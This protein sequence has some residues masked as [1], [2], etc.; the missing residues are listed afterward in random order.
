MIW[1]VAI[2][3]DSVEVHLGSSASLHLVNFPVTDFHDTVNGLA[4]G[5]N[6][7]G[8]G[9]P[10]TLSL[11]IHWTTLLRVNDSNEGFRGSYFGGITTTLAWSI[12]QTGFNLVSDPGS[13]SR[14]V[15]SPV[16]DFGPFPNEFVTVGREQNGV[17]F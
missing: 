7:P 17:F 8:N 10:A 11:D 5:S 16:I 2:P 14:A 13:T 1:T 3:S 9:A 4:N 15:R 12:T 6:Y